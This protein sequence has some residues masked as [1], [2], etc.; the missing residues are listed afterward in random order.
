MIEPKAGTFLGHMTARIRDELWKK[1]TL[2]RKHGACF[3]AWKSPTEQG[4][5]FRIA[6]EPSRKLVDFEGLHLV[7]ISRD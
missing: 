5:Q 4:F 6:G 1:A 2:D 7:S 3:Q